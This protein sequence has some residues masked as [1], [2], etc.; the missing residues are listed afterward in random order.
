MDLHLTVATLLT[1][2]QRRWRRR[3]VAERSVDDGAGATG[4]EGERGVAHRAQGV[5]VMLNVLA[6]GQG[7]LWFSRDCSLE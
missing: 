3:L 1:T 6:V 2:K 4:G 5:T 7:A